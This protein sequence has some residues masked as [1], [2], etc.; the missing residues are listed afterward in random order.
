M[1]DL[2]SIDG[3][4]DLPIG[5]MSAD[6]TIQN[7]V[8]ATHAGASQF[9]EKPLSADQMVEVA[10]YFTTVTENVNSRVLIVDD[11]D[12]FG[13]HIEAILRSEGMEVTYLEEPE[14]ILQ[15]I[16][17][18]KP[19]ILLLDVMMPKISGFEVCRML[20]ST[21]VWNEIP[22]LFL[23]AESSPDVRLECFRA[24]GD[25]YIEKPVVREELLARI[26]VR[27]ERIRLFREK[28]DRDGLTGLPNRRA[29]IDLFKLRIAEGHRYNSP[30]SLCLLDLDHF[31]QINDHYGHLAG[32]KVLVGLGK[33]LSSRF[34]TIDVRGR[35]G[36][37]EF[38]VVFYG[39]DATTSKLILTRV[40]TEF[41]K[42]TFEGD[43]GEQF[44]V[45][46]SCGISTFPKDGDTFD[47]L[48][49]RADELLYAA[50]KAGRDCIEI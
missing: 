39:E 23:T 34:R 46:F 40:L 13:A 6:S 18:V 5:I 38:T 15:T 9:L 43:H 32:D 42:M 17:Q 37:E 44:N 49:R 21:T 48:F 35:W 7:R 47:A 16:E 27:L 3:I 28:A 50:K 45:T 36:G 24:G 19:D 30:A 8:A 12:I 29:F 20:R 2:R 11:D 31:K 33:L 14:R 1:R 41:R 10:R 25:D 4:G 22:I 26:G